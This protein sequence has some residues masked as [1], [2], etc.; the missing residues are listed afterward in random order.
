MATLNKAMSNPEVFIVEHYCACP[1]DDMSCQQL[2]HCYID[3]DYGMA[4]LNKAMSNP[5]VFIGEV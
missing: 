4:T 1:L 5:E 2:L 3:D